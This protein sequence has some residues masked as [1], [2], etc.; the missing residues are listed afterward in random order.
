MRRE[1]E[2][3]PID[4]LTHDHGHLGAL[5]HVVAGA[6]TRLQS[7][8]GTSDEPI[9]ELVHAVESLRDTL[10]L[11]FSREEEG[12]FPFVDAQVP[13][14]TRQVADLLGDHDRVIDGAAELIRTAERTVG[15][16]TDVAV[17]VAAYERFVEVYAAHAQAEQALLRAVDDVLDAAGRRALRA[18]LEAI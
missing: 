10:L 13:G 14:L 6:V 11:H 8:E 5:V 7:A 1:P 18:L 3:D 9:D 12:L 17:C 16:P 15:R 4:Q 2:S